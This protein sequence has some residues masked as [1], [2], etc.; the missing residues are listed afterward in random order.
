MPKT[1]RDMEVSP[2]ATPVDF[3]PKRKHPAFLLEEE[4]KCLMEDHVGTPHISELHVDDD[5][6]TTQLKVEELS[7]GGEVGGLDITGNL[8]KGA[9]TADLMSL[10]EI[11]T[12]GT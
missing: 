11:V 2:K 1:A 6:N 9:D 3:G 4:P 12:I 5:E 8:I 7:V 10:P